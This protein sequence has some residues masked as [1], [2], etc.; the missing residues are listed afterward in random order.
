MKNF[1][2]IG[3]AGYVAPRHLKAIKDT[4]NNLVSA[5]DTSDA[6][7]VVDRYFPNTDFFTDQSLFEIFLTENKLDYLTICSPNHLH[8]KH[9]CL[10]LKH[11]INVICE[12]PLVL[13]PAE[14]YDLLELEKNSGLTINTILQLRL[15]PNIIELKKQVVS[16]MNS[17]IYD[18]ELTYITPRGKWYHTSWKG[19][20]RKS[21]GIATNIGI[22]LFDLL[23]YL[24]GA[25]KESIVHLHEVDVAAGFL[26]LENARVKWL[27]STS[28]TIIPNCQKPLRSMNV[29]GDYVE[30]NSGFEELHTKSYQEIFTGNGFGI[31]TV[32]PSIEITHEI[33]HTKPTGITG[34]YHPLLKSIQNRLP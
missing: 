2:L 34:D 26:E 10:G 8:Y 15:H 14:A 29:S 24:F 16:K 18:V 21:G 20:V 4:G 27:L 31:E 32:I 12:K 19:D 5:Y 23:T 22:H 3:L 28:S 33:R 9:V 13:N 11:D 6:V 1:G 25:V 30:F 17:E 7:G